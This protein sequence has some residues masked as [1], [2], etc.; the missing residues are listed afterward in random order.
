[1]S[2]ICA[3]YLCSTKSGDD[4]VD[5]GLSTSS[6]KEQGVETDEADVEVED[7]NGFRNCQNDTT[8][9]EVLLQITGCKI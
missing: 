4:V 1:V 3:I 7:R 5:S 6:K 9:F 2:G 8:D